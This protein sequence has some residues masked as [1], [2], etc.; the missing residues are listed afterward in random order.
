MKC[1]YCGFTYDDELVCPICGTPAAPLEQTA[2]FAP[3][4]AP[5]VQAPVSASSPC[6]EPDIEENKKPAAAKSGKGLKIAALCVLSVIA[7]A[8]LANVAIQAFSLS[9]ELKHYR[10]SA[11]VMDREKELYDKSFKLVE[12]EPDFDYDYDGSNSEGYGLSEKSDNTVHKV[13]E[14]Y[15][16]GS[17]V[18]TLKSVRVSQKTANFDSTKQQVAFFVEVTNNTNS[19]QIY[20]IPSLTLGEKLDAEAFAFAEFNNSG[21]DVAYSFDPGESC[22]AVFYYNLPTENQTLNVT[23]ST[24]SQN[25]TCFVETEYT[26]ETKDI[27]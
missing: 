27:K 8:L 10:K 24:E 3:Q 12:S 23:V 19:S 21:E 22:S 9:A 18:I 4:P 1:S 15:D 2:P 5:T 7:A 26:L 25:Y 13:G 17:G 16:F 20:E 6:V 11:D 14:S